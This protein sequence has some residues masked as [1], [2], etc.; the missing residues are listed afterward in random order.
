MVFRTVHKMSCPED[1]EIIDFLD[2]QCPSERVSALEAHFD[3]CEDCRGLV[4]E[5]ARS[6]HQSGAGASES[7]D[8][9]LRSGGDLVSTG[10]QVGRYIVVN[11]IGSGAMG[12][13]Y[14]AYD[15]QLDRSI[16]LK[17]VRVLSAGDESTE[18]ARQR[19]LREAKAMAKLSD[20]NVITIFDASGFG[21]WVYLAMELVDGIDLRTWLE[22]KPREWSTIAKVFA[23]AARGL[24]SAHKAGIVHRDFKPA[25]VLIDKRQQVRVADFGLAS[26][27]GGASVNESG[28]VHLEK[29]GELT[30]TGTV[31]GTPA[32][33]SPEV[34]QGGIGTVLSDQYSFGISLKGAFGGKDAPNGIRAIIDRATQTIPEQRFASMRDLAEALEG[35]VS[36]RRRGKFAGWIGLGVFI[37]VI[38]GLV[39]MRGQD[40]EQ[41]PCH[42]AKQRLAGIWDAPSKV[43]VRFGLIAQDKKNASS[44]FA[45]VSSSF[46]AYAEKWEL[47][48]V[49]A[50]QA[51]VSQQQSPSLSDRR[52]RCLQSELDRFEKIAIAFRRPTKEMLRDAAKIAS[53]RNDLHYCNDVDAL[54]RETPIPRPEDA[55]RVAAAT[56]TLRGIEALVA[57]APAR[58]YLVPLEE[59]SEEATALGYSRLEAEVLTQLGKARWRQGDA[60]AG[61]ET[62]ILAVQA[63]ERSRSPDIKVSAMTSMVSIVGDRMAKHDEGLRIAQLAEAALL[64][65]PNPAL[66]GELLNSRAGVLLRKGEY[67]K[68]EAGFRKVY[69]ILLETHGPKY[70]RLGGVL[71]NIAVVIGFD[72]TKNEESL[73]FYNRALAFERA[74]KGPQ[75]PDIAM[76]LANRSSLLS[77]LGRHEESLADL[78]ESLQI[79]KQSLGDAH[80]LVLDN[81]RQLG[82]AEHAA[83][84][85]VAALETYQEGARLAHLA[86]A[87]GDI[88]HANITSDIGRTLL[89]MDRSEEGI[90]RLEKAVQGWEEAVKTQGR[91]LTDRYSQAMSQYLLASALWPT[92]PKRAVVIVKAAVLLLADDFPE[93]STT[94]K[95]WIDSQR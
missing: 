37:I 23:S 82:R 17:L 18:H 77:A 94:M 21:D 34:K 43:A 36:G 71:S 87:E 74:N 92:Q 3:R 19:L 66:Y 54:L 49:Q 22:Q 31:M 64:A 15:P 44:A 68:A 33:M 88:F 35:E 45:S 83:K 85:Y 63:A 14:R 10:D 70:Y 27:V 75:H 76:V 1:N 73:E 69:D 61:L 58:E 6:L 55:E 62:L 50:C 32:Y 41:G 2:G 59:L 30:E 91:S 80:P 7:A 60:A 25:N 4:A 11:Q 13:V 48:Y 84:D 40:A 20:P 78:R 16:A 57:T 12:V 79:Q 89:K 93:E 42:D 51:R 56:K 46:D 8:W 47:S 95:A 90:S 9:K 53:F 39:V 52:M 24:W 67:E 81:Y 86:L 38:A 65:N 29:A 5:L 28:Q 72:E 26:M